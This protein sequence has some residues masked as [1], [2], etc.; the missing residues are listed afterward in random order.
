MVFARALASSTA[1]QSSPGLPQVPTQRVGPGGSTGTSHG[2]R[3]QRDDRAHPR[4][5]GKADDQGSGDMPCTLTLISESPVGRTI[6]SYERELIQYRSMEKRLRDALAE[7]E[8]LLR[9]KDELIHQQELLKKESDHR[10]LNDLQMTISLL[11]LQSRDRRM[12]KRPRNWPLRPT[13][14]R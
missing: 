14:F 4:A 8:A 7:S 1:S 12:Q 2:R 10:L 5:L 11:S 3:R 6:A 9:Q 13:A